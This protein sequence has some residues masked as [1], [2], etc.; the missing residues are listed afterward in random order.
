[1]KQKKFWVIISCLV[2]TVSALTLK[3]NYGK[4]PADESID[5]TK[6]RQDELF[7]LALSE[8]AHIRRTTLLAVPVRRL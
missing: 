2:L 3:A 4:P 1:M 5:N 8:V 7:E 6:S